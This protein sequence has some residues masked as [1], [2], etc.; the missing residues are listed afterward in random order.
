MKI[1]DA[2]EQLSEDRRLFLGQSRFEVLQ[3][4][5]CAGLSVHMRLERYKVTQIH[6]QL[7]VLSGWNWGG[8]CAFSG[9]PIL[10]LL[11]FSL[12]GGQ[13]EVITGFH[14]SQQGGGG[15]GGG[16][17]VNFCSLPAEMSP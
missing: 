4:F 5:M 7:I 17:G 9:R 3:H 2:P 6:Q 14:L 10:F 15:E 12:A 8:A 1:T 13:A 16:A 11:F